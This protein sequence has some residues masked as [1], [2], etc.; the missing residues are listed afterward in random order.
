ML[1]RT[2]WLCDGTAEVVER[3]NLENLKRRFGKASYSKIDRKRSDAYVVG[4]LVN[5]CVL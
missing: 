3:K 2:V 1:K 5:K 4:G